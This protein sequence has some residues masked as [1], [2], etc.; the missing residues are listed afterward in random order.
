MSLIEYALVAAALLC[1]LVAGLV[2]CFAV[3]VMPGIRTLDDR[4]FLRSF[5]AMDR[6]IQ[7]TSPLFVLVWLGSALVLL[8]TTVL[9]FWH[10]EGCALLLVVVA[11]AAYLGGVQFPTFT[12]N[13]P[14][15]NRVQSLDLDSLSEEE[16]HQE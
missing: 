7:D 1:G 4:E 10:L 6:V 2:F 9:A 11:C 13:I 8:G 12:I 3:V 5:K 15:N 14:L 16:L